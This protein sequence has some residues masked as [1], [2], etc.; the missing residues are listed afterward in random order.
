MLAVRVAVTASIIALGL[1]I[2]GCESDTEPN[3]SAAALPS[4]VVTVA[5]VVRKDVT[6]SFE[7]I[8]RIEAVDRVELRARVEGY[9][10][11]RNFRE[12]RDVVEGDVLFQIE[13]EPYEAVVDQRKADLARAQATLTN[14]E[15]TLKRNDELRKKGTVSQAALDDAIAA[16]AEARAVVLQARAALRRSQLDLDYT[17]VLSPITGRVGRAA[18]S[19][20]NLVGPESGALAT[21]VSLD[22]I[23][24][25]IAVS[26][27]DLIE[28]R[29]RGI[30][31]D[32][33][34][35][36]P[37][38][39]L[40]DGTAYAEAGY[41]DFLDNQ[42]DL[43]TDTITARAVFPNPDKVLWPGEFVTV[44]VRQKEPLAALVVPQAAMQED[45]SGR[46]V[47][48]VDETG[49]V[50]IRKVT[51]G[52]QVGT[53]WIIESGLEKGEQ[54][55]VQ[56]AQKVRPGLEVSAVPAQAP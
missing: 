47:L 44:S 29:K 8:G 17:K 6:P 56:G 30:D 50:T 36:A 3:Q 54:V 9:L 7:Y 28:A 49:K 24:V 2:S 46:Y 53:D 16:E 20:G 27:K 18:F 31:L 14:A 48:V 39:K 42:V 11:V 41:F 5:R 4:P 35:V 37:S 22:P 25:T 43:T 32:N 45:Q 21:V 26:E 33:P 52:Q 55:I 51:T 12:G 10:E 23:Y 1:C 38:L 15:L 19:V 13:S 34:R 40:A